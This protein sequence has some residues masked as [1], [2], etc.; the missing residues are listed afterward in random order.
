MLGGQSS[1]RVSTLASGQSTAGGSMRVKSDH[2]CQSHSLAGHGPI[3]CT[4]SATCTCHQ[5][6]NCPLHFSTS[7]PLTPLP[8]FSTAPHRALWLHCLWLAVCVG[9]ECR[10]TARGRIRRARAGSGSKGHPRASLREVGQPRP[11]SD[12]MTVDGS[13]QPHHSPLWVCIL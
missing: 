12:R 7:A 6:P 9:H 2:L 8:T 5:P 3:S 1:T 4:I 10:T 11:E 13:T